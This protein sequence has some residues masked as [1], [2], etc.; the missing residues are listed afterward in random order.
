MTVLVALKDE[1]NNRIILGTDKQATQGYTKI[2]VE[3]KI[4]VLNI[5]VVDGYGEVIRNDKCFI[6][7]SG[8]LYMNSFIEYCFEAP[9]LPNNMEFI[10]YL[11]KNFLNKL[12]EELVKRQLTEEH[13]SQFDSECGFIIVYND[14]IFSV[15]NNFGVTPTMDNV[16]VEGSGYLEALASLYTSEQL[17]PNIGAVKKVS[18]AI[19]AASH[20][21]LY[22]DGESDIRIIDY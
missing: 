8:R 19:E 6:A 9:S 21:N 2:Y 4:V 14:E 12:R 15:E 11:H 16:C 18:L 1:K 3:S 13:N 10:E 5:P 22:C 17:N 20:H 7:I